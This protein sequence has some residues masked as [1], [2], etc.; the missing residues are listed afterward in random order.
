MSRFC[1]KCDLY[2]S[3]EMIW[4]NGDEEKVQEY[5]DNAKFYM[6]V[7][8]RK[9]PIKITNRK[10]L[11]LY[12]PFL[13]S[14]SAHSNGK[15]TVVLC[16]DSFIDQEEEERLKYSL[17]ECLR[18]YKKTKRNHKEINMENIL[19]DRFGGPTSYDLEIAK[20]VIEDGKKA[21]I[22]GVHTYMHEYY[23]RE[24]Y[25]C[26]VKLGWTKMEAF[27]WVY[28]EWYATDDTINERVYV[29]EEE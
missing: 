18:K 25:E 21:T 16:S 22:D 28:K 15:H 11:A 26:L 19:P 9:M 17:K 3:V 5:I 20:R 24:W 8:D 12:Y 7:H 6:Y 23:R 13:T 29:E 14:M 27:N 1:G 10:E 2:D 4:A